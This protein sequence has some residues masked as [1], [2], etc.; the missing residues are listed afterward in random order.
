VS[1]LLVMA[2]GAEG[3]AKA[4]KEIAQLRRPPSQAQSSARKIAPPARKALPP[5][6]KKIPAK[7][8][9]PEDIIP[10]GDDFED[11]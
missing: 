8:A 1:E 9:K 2:G 11:F 10:M 7:G 3:S 4:R 5:A 6:P